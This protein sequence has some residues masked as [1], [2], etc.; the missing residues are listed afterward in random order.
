[1]INALFLNVK[2]FTTYIL[3]RDYDGYYDSG[4]LYSV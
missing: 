2:T 4:A 1:M 3:S